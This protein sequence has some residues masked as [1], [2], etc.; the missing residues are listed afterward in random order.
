MLEDVGHGQGAEAIEQLEPSAANPMPGVLGDDSSNSGEA[1]D[2]E[3][4]D[5]PPK[6]GAKAKDASQRRPAT[7]KVEDMSEDEADLP[8]LCAFQSVPFWLHTWP[9]AS[10]A[11]VGMRDY[12]LWLSEWFLPP[13]ILALF[14]SCVLYAKLCFCRRAGE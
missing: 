12:E 9:S 2:A 7:V 13:P 3:H 14:V 8:P 1:K 11:E 10:T 4:R 6:E 5:G